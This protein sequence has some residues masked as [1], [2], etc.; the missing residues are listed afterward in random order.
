MSTYTSD[1]FPHVLLTQVG[2]GG[3]G[4]LVRFNVCG[5]RKQI[6]G[7]LKHVCIFISEGTHLSELTT[8]RAA[9]YS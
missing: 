1:R 9:E 5:P 7:A 2:N 4:N 3:A 8:Q 6:A